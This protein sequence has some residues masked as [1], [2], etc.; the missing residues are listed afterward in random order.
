MSRY[1]T[2]C[3]AFRP[4]SPAI[5]R[6]REGCPEHPA[7]G[8]GIE[9]STEKK[10][11]KNNAIQSKETARSSR[12]NLDTSLDSR[13]GDIG[14]SAVAAALPYR[15]KLKTVTDAPTVQQLTEETAEDIVV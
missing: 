3:C 10:M 15:S 13:Y 12:P 1:D 2:I 14:I 11:T 6:Y 5:P 8:D 7:G 4:H 9:S